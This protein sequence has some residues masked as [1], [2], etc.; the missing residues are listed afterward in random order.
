MIKLSDTAVVA[1]YKE[2]M[3]QECQLGQHNVTVRARYIDTRSGSYAKGFKF[4][5]RII[6]FLERKEKRV[7]V[8]EGEEHEYIKTLYSFD[9]GATWHDGEHSARK[10]AGRKPI[11]LERNSYKELAYDAIQA[12]N[13]KYGF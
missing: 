5:T 1:E 7:S 2:H 11:V 12:I 6:A 9:H 13:R 8:Y 4:V 10:A 3:N